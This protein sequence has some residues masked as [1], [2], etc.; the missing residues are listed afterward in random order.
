MCPWVCMGTENKEYQDELKQMSLNIAQ[1]ENDFLHDLQSNEKLLRLQEEYFVSSNYVEFILAACL[2]EYRNVYYVPRTLVEAI[3]NF[4]YLRK[5]IE[6]DNN[7]T[8]IVVM[9]ENDS[10]HC[11]VAA[12]LLAMCGSTVFVIANPIQCPVNH[13][14][15]MDDS[16]RICVENM[17]EYNGIKILYPLEILLEEVSLGDNRA[18]LIDYITKEYTENDFATV[19]CSGELMDNLCEFPLLRKRMERLD[20][21]VSE[22]M[23]KN[24]SFAWCGNY[25]TYISMIYEFDVEEAINSPAE[26]DFSIVIPARNSSDSLRYTL[27][28]C[29]G[30]QYRGEYE[31]VISDNSTNGSMDIY[32]LVRELND[33]RIKYYK[34]P[35]NLHLPKSFEYAFL[36]AKGE[37]ILS[38]GSDDG[39]LPWSLDVIKN[40][41]EQYP[42][43]EIISWDRAFYV[44]PGCNGGQQNQFIVPRKYEKGVIDIKKINCKDILAMV[45]QDKSF[46]YIMPTLYINSGFKRSYFK[47]LM[48]KTGRLWDG[49]CQDLYMGVI[50]ISIKDEILSVEYPLTIAG[51][52]NLSQGKIANEGCRNAEEMSRSINELKIIHNIGGFSKS[53]IE[54]LMP[55][56][57]SDVSSLYNCLLRAVARGIIPE[58]YLEKVFDWKKMFIECI[59]MMKKDDMAYD[60]NVHYIRYTA[61]KHG[62]DFL[63]WFDEEIYPVLMKP[64]EI[65]NNTQKAEIKR[66][67]DT[68][69]QEDGSL[70]VDASEHGVENIYDAVLL[71]Q[72]ITGLGE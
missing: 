11:N 28:T 19:L 31:I 57:G 3:P 22:E 1:R 52:T 20:N 16:V 47:T 9:S 64:E 55:E 34:T 42:E 7:N 38:I 43:E 71:F 60:K 29:L 56:I 44:W 54:R 65:V 17:Q 36:K 8:F 32:N 50:T 6:G 40:V 10:M 18:E 58:L 48:E 41:I 24:L 69:I 15:N 62:K 4:G 39:M 30:I 70:V 72:R 27:K 46:M 2:L 49:I 51:M 26:C 67:Y 13:R 5:Q 45:L 33:D 59:R 53:R 66:S 35:R 37:F 21:F 14:I 61:A 68:G 25:L 63:R 23:E 12:N